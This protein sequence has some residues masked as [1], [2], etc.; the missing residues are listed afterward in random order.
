MKQYNGVP[1]DGRAMQIMLATSEVAP[2]T[3]PRPKGSQLKVFM[4]LIKIPIKIVPTKVEPNIGNFRT[5]P[6]IYYKN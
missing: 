3:S 6:V 5:I 1:L 4:I 2:I